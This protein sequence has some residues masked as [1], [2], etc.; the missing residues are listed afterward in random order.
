MEGFESKRYEYH[1]EIEEDFFAFY[2]V[3]RLA[4]YSVKSGDNI[5]DLCVNEL[6]VPF[7]LLKKYNPD[8]DFHTLTIAQ[9]INYPV[10]IPRSS[11]EL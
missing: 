4:R 1:K 5:C 9:I 11:R 10:I 6:E 8:I 2:S 7:W 3:Q